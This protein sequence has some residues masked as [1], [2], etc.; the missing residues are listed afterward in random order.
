MTEHESPIVDDAGVALL[1]R[2][3]DYL[4]A[5]P[6]EYAEAV[7]AGALRVFVSRAPWPYYAR[8]RPELDLH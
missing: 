6:R 1:R 8:P 2:C 4:D 3:D 5:S 7:D